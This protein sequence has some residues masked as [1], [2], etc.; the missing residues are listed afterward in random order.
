MTDWRRE[1]TETY[2]NLAPEFSKFFATYG[3]RADDVALAFELAGNP[4]DARVLEIGCGD[5]RD[6]AEIVK[7][8][9]NYTGL[10]IAEEFIKLARTNVA[11]G[12]FEV[13]DAL[14][15]DYPTNLDIVFAFASLL[16]LDKSEVMEV[17][18]D[19]HHALKP[20]GIGYISLK[21]ASEYKEHHQQDEFGGRMF[22]YYNPPLIE[23]L[24]GEGYD[25]VHVD[26]HVKKNTDWFTIALQKV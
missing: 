18:G 1:T 3:S 11:V 24:A 13:G 23:E 20:Q 17:L 19:I 7:R 22:Y 9:P 10:D 15:Y 4:V 16:H 12:K 5:G 26:R 6:A 25:T 8:T 21:Y 14:D 2:N